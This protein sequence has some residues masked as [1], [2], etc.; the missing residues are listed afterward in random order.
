[1]S[2]INEKAK[3]A[4]IN[5]L[6][7]VEVASDKELYQILLQSKEQ[8]EKGQPENLVFSKLNSFLTTYLLT[9]QFKIPKGAQE[10]FKYSQR[11]AASYR[12]TAMQTML[13]MGLGPHGGF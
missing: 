12:G 8:L 5:A 1:M 13:F 10:L 11:I 3:N 4:L 2:N 7:D 9:H 6:L